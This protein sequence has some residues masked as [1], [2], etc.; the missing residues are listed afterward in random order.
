MTGPVESVAFRIQGLKISYGGATVLHG[1]DLD[2]PRNQ[3]TVILG[4]SGSG[5]T[6]LLRTLN[7]LDEDRQGFKRHGCVLFD[8]EDLFDPDQDVNRLRERIGLVFQKPI[9][10]PAS[11]ESNVLFGVRHLGTSPRSEWPEIVHRMLSRV[12]LFDEVKDR[13]GDSALHLS[14][15][16]Q[17]RLSIARALAIDPEV[18]LLDEPTASLDPRSAGIIG[19]LIQG[20]TPEKTVILVTH[21][22]SQ[23]EG[24]GQFLAL[25][26][27][28]RLVES[29]PA[30]QVLDNPADPVT[31]RFLSPGGGGA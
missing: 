21:R 27:R 2:I 3:V 8:G 11:I 31:R 17:Q 26:E 28:G 12:A 20:L 7:R 25:V 4:P 9:M 19:D 10:F 30:S 5:K 13:L 15:G 24:L 23:A 29:G 6:T 1:L 14:Q 16:Q 22:V 18:L